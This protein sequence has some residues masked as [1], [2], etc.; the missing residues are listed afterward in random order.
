MELKV[1]LGFEVDVS[2]P[3]LFGVLAQ[4]YV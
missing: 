1:D 4:W 2:L 3:N